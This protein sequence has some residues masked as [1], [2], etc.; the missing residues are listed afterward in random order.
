MW[1][2]HA[3]VCFLLIAQEPEQWPIPVFLGSLFVIKKWRGWPYLTVCVV[4][5]GRGAQTKECPLLLQ[6]LGS[7]AKK[8][9]T[10]SSF[11]LTLDHY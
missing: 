3:Y 7:N 9:L 8:Y 11:T 6:C 4:E 10:K 1:L 2:T 5:W